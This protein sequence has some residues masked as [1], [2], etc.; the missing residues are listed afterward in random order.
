MDKNR[1]GKRDIIIPVYFNDDEVNGDLTA[2][3][4]DMSAPPSFMEKKT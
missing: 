2:Q 3:E 1:F 4:V